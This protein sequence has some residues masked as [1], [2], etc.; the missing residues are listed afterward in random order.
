MSYG[1]G[2]AKWVPGQIAFQSTRTGRLPS[3]QP[4]IEAGLPYAPYIEHGSYAYGTPDIARYGRDPYRGLGDVSMTAD[5]KK[6]SR[7][8]VWVEGM[9]CPSWK[10]Q[11]LERAMREAMRLVGEH[12]ANA[13]I[14]LAGCVPQLVD[15]VWSAVAHK[16][17]PLVNLPHS[18][19]G[20]TMTTGDAIRRLENQPYVVIN[21]RTRRKARAANMRIAMK[22]AKAMAKR[23]PGVPIHIH[24]PART[25]TARTLVAVLEKTPKGMSVRFNNALRGLGSTLTDWACDSQ[26]FA[27]SWAERVNSGL[28]VGAQ[29]AVLGAG[30]AGLI[31][32]VLKRPLLGT[33]V[34]AAVGFGTHAIWTAPQRVTD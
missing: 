10:G 17:A 22:L 3:V 24:L 8:E 1:M 19:S 18:L 25:F 6:R 11:G 32:A 16:A 4:L 9:R 21:H 15:T 30:I 23:S 34:G 2:Q 14:Y 27:K 31:G 20:A 28:T 5:Q 12:Q 7:F 26:E 13:N 29:A 33:A